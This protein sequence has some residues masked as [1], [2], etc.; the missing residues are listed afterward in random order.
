MEVRQMR[1]GYFGLSKTKFRAKVNTV[2]LCLLSNHKTASISCRELKK[3]VAITAPYFHD[4]FQ[5]ETLEEAIKIMGE[6]S[7]AKR[8]KNK[9]SVTS[10]CFSRHSLATPRNTSGV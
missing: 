10:R 4:G 9:Q 8:L 5:T 2:A 3:R 6:S 1:F 7:L